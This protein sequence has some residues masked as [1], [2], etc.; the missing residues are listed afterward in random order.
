ML[1]ILIEARLRA[2]QVD[3]KHGSP[4]SVK[5]LMQAYNVVQILACLYMTMGLLPCVRFL[6]VFHH[7]TSA[8]C[9]RCTWRTA[10]APSGG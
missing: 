7:S 8:W 5:L 6:H 2:L 1:A 9:P 4:F 3:L 10:T